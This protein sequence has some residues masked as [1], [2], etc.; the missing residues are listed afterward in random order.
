MSSGYSKPAPDSITQTGARRSQEERTNQASHNRNIKVE[1]GVIK[2]MFFDE[3]GTLTQVVV[4]PDN[5]NVPRDS[6][7]GRTQEQRMQINMPA[8]TIAALYGKDLVGRRVRVEYS[9]VHIHKGTVTIVE[10]LNRFTP[11]ALELPQAP[12]SF[13]G[14]GGKPSLGFGS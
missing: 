3:E 8:E 4:G 9:G 2:K 7:F 1:Y 13:A 10:D 5:P 11:K 12:S 14:P 6:V